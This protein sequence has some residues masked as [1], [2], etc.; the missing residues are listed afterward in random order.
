MTHRIVLAFVVATAVVVAGCAPGDDAPDPE[1][2]SGA[3][4]VTPELLARGAETYKANCVPCH[5]P[6][7]RGD[8][9]SAA[10]LKPPPRDHTNPELMETLS[11]KRIAETVRMGGIISGYPNMP[12]SPHLRGEELVGLVAF[13]RSLHREEVESVDLEGVGQ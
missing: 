2:S 10:T 13:V 9:P 12:A 4:E 11:D 3:V 5:G 7:G 1:S 8:G 6:G